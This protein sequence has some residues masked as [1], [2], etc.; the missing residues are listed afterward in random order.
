[1]AAT[2]DERGVLAERRGRP[3]EQD[4][5]VRLQDALFRVRELIE[6]T[7]STS[8]RGAARPTDPLPVTHTGRSELADAVAQVLDKGGRDIAIALTEA[9]EFT[10]AVLGHLDRVPTSLPVR[11]LCT[12]TAADVRA[13]RLSRFQK[14]PRTEIRVTDRELRAALVVDG[15]AAVVSGTAVEGAAV[16]IGDVG[17]V[18]ALEL[19]FACVWAGC[20][21]L[22][23][24]LNFGPRL[25]SELGRDVLRQ[26]C[27][28]ST[29]EAAARDLAVSLRTY[30][31]YV[32]DIM[33]ELDAGSRFQVGVRAIELGLVSA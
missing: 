28:G 27:S 20:P 13:D 33:R 2:A 14:R 6:S 1:M 15:T 23:D 21:R 22:N 9:G 18:Q 17:T 29:D 8:M 3:E 10:D 19:L 26:L 7:L 32:A 11:V 12:A 31:R 30:R 16:V 24:H 4:A 25:R 5:A